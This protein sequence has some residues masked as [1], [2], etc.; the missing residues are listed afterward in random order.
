MEQR[1]LST[2]T[3][4]VQG[5]GGSDPSLAP[6]IILGSV[7]ALCTPS[8]PWLG[9]GINTEGPQALLGVVGG[10]RMATALLG[11]CTGHRIPLGGWKEPQRA[12][13]AN[14]LRVTWRATDFSGPKELRGSI[15]AGP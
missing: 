15:S 2:C 5:G 1:G 14:S 3:Q 6:P 4:Q 11:S 10:G 12:T 8:P 13:I 7:Q 9:R